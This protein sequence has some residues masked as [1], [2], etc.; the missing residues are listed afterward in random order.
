MFRA[1]K[2]FLL[3]ICLALPAFAT[4]LEA[5]DDIHALVDALGAGGFPEREAAIKALV[6]SGDPHVG[7]IL[8][9]LS[10]GQLYVNSEEGGP[11]LLQGGSDD[12]PTYSDPIT[13]EAVAISI[14]TTCPRS[15][16]TIPCAA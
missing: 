14:R 15:R 6:A 3:T 12:E 5:Q 1:I 2:I 9:Q 16:S 11:V 8:Q 13:G 4:A 10:D 7:Q